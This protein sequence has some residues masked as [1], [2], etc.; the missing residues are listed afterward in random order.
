METLEYSSARRELSNMEVDREKKPFL[1]D[2]RCDLSGSW[3]PWSRVG[4]RRFPNVISN[5]HASEQREL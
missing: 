3:H 2:C 4:E 1:D 5:D